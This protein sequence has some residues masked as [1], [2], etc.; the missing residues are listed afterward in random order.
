MTRQ[1]PV[2]I[3]NGQGFW[4]DSVLGPLQLVREGPI[5]YLTLDYLAEVT[6]SIMQ[7]LR[8]RD[9]SAGYATDFIQLLDRILPECVDKGIRIVANAGGVNPGAC[10]RAAA[11]VARKHGLSQVRIGVVRGDDLLER[12]EVLI[13][14]GEKL[15]NLDTGEALGPHLDEVLSA[16][17]YLGAAPIVE[18]LTGGADIVITGRCTDPSLVVAPMIHEFGWSLQDYDRIAA[19]TVAGHII[20]CGTQCTGGNFDDWRNVPDLATIGYPVI[21]AS[22]DGSFVVTKHPGTGGLV[23]KDTVTAQL[24]YE[25]GDPACYQSPD[26]IADFSSITLSD[27]GLD[28]IRVDGVGG[29]NRPA[30]TRSP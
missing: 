16:N 10:A 7:K 8:S 27:D 4:G 22:D 15:A 13:E 25:L 1:R 21:E 29:E 11:E 26:V 19:A 9:P 2:L 6:M 5:D 3:G 30:R 24:L 23:T 14:Q 12:L 20:E 28:R 17:V 18:A